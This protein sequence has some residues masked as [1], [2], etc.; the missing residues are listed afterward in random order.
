MPAPNVS[1]ANFELMFDPFVVLKS[2]AYTSNSG[3]VGTA[4]PLKHM[5]VSV[6]PHRQGVACVEAAHADVKMVLSV[7]R[8][9]LVSLTGEGP[10]TALHVLPSGKG[11]VRSVA[12]PATISHVPPAARG[13]RQPLV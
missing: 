4:V 7:C 2:H 3:P 9:M 12:L 6:R 13:S 1:V 5:P 10:T 8:Q 11:P